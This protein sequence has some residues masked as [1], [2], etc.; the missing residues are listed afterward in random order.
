MTGVTRAELDDHKLRCE[1]L[2]RTDQ[3]HL[4][5]QAI[6]EAITKGVCTPYEKVYVRR[7]G[8]PVPVLIGGGLLPGISGRGIV[9][10]I[11]L[12]ERKKAEEK[13]RESQQHYAM[14][15]AAGGV[16]V[17][18]LDVESG[19]LRTDRALA[20]RLGLEV[21]ESYPRNYWRKLIHP[22]DLA[23]V[24]Q[25]EHMLD[26]GSLKD[27]ESTTV[28]PE[29]E[30]RGLHSDG[31]TRWFVVRGTVVRGEDGRAYRALGTI[32]DVTE[33]KKAEV[34]LRESEEKNRAILQALPDLMFV[35][36]KDGVYLDYHAKNSKALLVPPE[37]FIGK[38]MRE[39]LPPELA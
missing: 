23:R 38:N 21:A 20:S 27:K 29:I 1:E 32:T 26:C 14:A 13:L 35:Q 3:L 24:L 11:D 7:D 31:S 37:Q 15:T 25:N 19:D 33:R 16:S 8:R 28:I 22:D 10:A 34:A 9:F 17:W 36:S 2:T 6:Q 5:K 12:S 30:F 39:V 18:D 4:V